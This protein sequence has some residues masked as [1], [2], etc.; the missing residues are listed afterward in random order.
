MGKGGGAEKMAGRWQG[1][2]GMGTQGCCVYPTSFQELK[3]NDEKRRIEKGN[4]A[5]WTA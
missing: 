2:A 3:T 4:R 1:L 5:G